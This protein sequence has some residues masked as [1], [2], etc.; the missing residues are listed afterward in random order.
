MRNYPFLAKKIESVER[1]PEVS[2]GGGLGRPVR[3]AAR[4][5]ARRRGAGA[6]ARPPDAPCRPRRRA[7]A[8]EPG[9]R[10]IVYPRFA[11]GRHKDDNSMI[12]ESENDC[13][14]GLALLWIQFNK[15]CMADSI[16][17]GLLAAI[18]SA[19]TSDLK[20]PTLHPPFLQL[21]NLVF[22]RSSSSTR[23][24]VQ[25]TCKLM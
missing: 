10:E 5:V 12:S 3:H 22:R 2:A 25:C 20:L 18:S 24:D 14:S 7:F 6:R 16:E 11:T 15:L 4:R 21:V 17:V 13:T 9:P 1:T 8:R 19:E 23:K